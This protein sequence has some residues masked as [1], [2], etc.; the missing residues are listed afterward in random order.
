MG[1]F[2]P[3]TRRAGL[4]LARHFL[5]LPSNCKLMD[6]SQKK[7]TTGLCLLGWKLGSGISQELRG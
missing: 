4:S 2:L 1:V 6:E 5:L 3:A 7:N